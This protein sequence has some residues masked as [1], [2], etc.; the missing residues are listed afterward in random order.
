VHARV[1]RLWSAWAGAPVRGPKGEVGPMRVLGQRVDLTLDECGA[2]VESSAGAMALS[3]GR[4]FRF[5]R[6]FLLALAREG[7][8][9]PYLLAWFE[10]DDLFRKVGSEE[11]R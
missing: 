5:D 2:R 3:A 9:R 8:E 6:P 10:N 1:E 7:A 11:P 4:A